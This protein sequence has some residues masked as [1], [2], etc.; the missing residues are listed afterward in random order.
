[1]DLPHIDLSKFD[2]VAFIWFDAEMTGDIEVYNTL[3]S[4]DK[5]FI[6]E[7]IDSCEEFIRDHLKN[8]RIFL[9]TS[10][11]LGRVIV[12]SIHD[13]PQLHLIYI[14]CQNIE[15]HSKW[16]N[17]YH[18]IQLVCN[19]EKD[20]IS[21]L[22]ID[23]AQMCVNIGDQHSGLNEHK[24]ALVWYERGLEKMKQHD[25]PTKNEF[26]NLLRY[27]IDRSTAACR[28][29]LSVLRKEAK[30]KIIYLGPSMN[31]L[32]LKCSAVEFSSDIESCKQLISANPQDEIILFIH[33]DFAMQTIPQIYLL[34]RHIYI[35]GITDEIRQIWFHNNFDPKEF[36][37]VHECTEN[38]AQFHLHNAI[39][40]NSVGKNNSIALEQLNSAHR[41]QQLQIPTQVTTVPQP[42]SSVLTQEKESDTVAEQT[43]GTSSQIVSAPMT[44]ALSHSSLLMSGD[45]N[46]VSFSNESS[47]S[48][49]STASTESTTVTTNEDKSKSKHSQNHSGISNPCVLCLT[50]EKQLAC[51]PCGHLVTCI[52]CSHLLKTCPICWRE[53]EAFVRIYI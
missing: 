10:G 47:T 33:A 25:G 18:K 22:A 1:M 27:K 51:I 12:P 50:D 7:R 44:L 48:V 37:Q 34:V 23:V 13:L 24:H 31:A 42:P 32:V 14:L 16:T 53:I 28:M 45:G 11:R 29:D 20:L 39:A 30:S 35:F 17:M 36:S 5:W 19:N 2:D 8:K 46:M 52:S 40:R 49:S 6:Y 43:T 38:G 26:V 3:S 15:G 21:D 9:V 41:M 4:P